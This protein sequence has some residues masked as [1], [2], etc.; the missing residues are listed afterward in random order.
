[1]P[2]DV[3]ADFS[4]ATALHREGRLDE[5][6]DIYRRLLKVGP[7]V[8]EVQR[9]LVLALLQAERPREAFAVARKAREEH[10]S[11]PHAHLLLGAALQAETKWE[12]ALSAFAAAAVLDPG[13]VEAHYM[14]G[15]MLA[16][17]GR[18]AEAAARFD[19][20]I[21]LDPRS[22]EALANRSVALA[23]LGRPE[24]ALRDCER[25]VELQPW[26]PRHLL[27][28]GGTLLELGRF[29]EATADAEAALRLAPHA[30]DAHFLKG[31]GL[32]GQA[33]TEGARN[34]FAA[35]LH[36][37]PDRPA[38]QAALARTERQLGNAAAAARLCEAALA[39]NPAAAAVWQELAEVRRE[40]VDLAGALEAVDKALAADPASAAA[41]TTKAR[42]LADLGRPAEARP[43]IDTALV[44]DPAF[45]MA[46]YLRATD[47]LSDGRWAEGWAGYESRASFLPPPY[48]P[49]PFKRWD[50][51]EVPD[52]LIVLG[53]QGIGDLIQFGRLLRLLADRGIS[54]RFLTQ[55]R[56]VPLLSRIDARVPVISDLS[57][58]DTAHPGLRWVPLGSLP[59]LIAPD[60]AAWPAPPY[61]PASADRIARWRELR[62]GAFMVGI[63]WQGNPSPSVDI[64]RSVPLETFAPL[65]ALPGVDLVSLQQGVGAEQIDTCTFGARIARLGPDW[66]AE[67]TFV[68]TAALLHHLDLVVT[69][70]TSMAHLAGARDVPAIVALRAA[71]DWRW[72]RSG[73]TTPLYPKL[74]L[75]RQARAG[76]FNEVFSR[77]ARMVREKMAEAGR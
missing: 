11:N 43:L 60:P 70:D 62:T 38:F 75:V 15:N 47:D 35:A 53:E 77:I 33:D 3:R 26:E 10:P 68:D 58:V 72:G 74:R 21:A 76:D 30:A 50:G 4:R 37:A 2:K 36:A 49:L 9:L 7:G 19:R 40:L 63:C 14:A 12:R 32:A 20:V 67:G 1:M 16:S 48:R 28:K 42:L 66:D 57:G 44:A 65:A 64:G 39:R 55:P 18:L 71:P 59:G 23:R 27:S 31:Q 8:F 54:T 34:A 24:E 46:L 41:L 69:T 29:K 17:L 5:A 45:P 56:Q 25:L 51:V 61:L 52:E 13:L 22:V 73:E 6:V